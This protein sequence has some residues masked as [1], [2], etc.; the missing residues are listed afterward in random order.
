MSYLDAIAKALGT[1]TDRAR[2]YTREVRSHFEAAP[3]YPQIL[4]ALRNHRGPK[5]TPGHIA[6]EIKRYLA[7]RED[8]QK[9]RRPRTSGKPRKGPGASGA[10]R[11]AQRQ[12]RPNQRKLKE[13]RSG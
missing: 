13:G 1:S 2:S 12:G 7:D 8:P 5:P 11:R 3:S 4:S 10:G 9:D 6:A